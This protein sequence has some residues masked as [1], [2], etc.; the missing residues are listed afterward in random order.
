MTYR[1]GDADTPADDLVARLAGRTI[2]LR[3]LTPADYS[4]LYRIFTHPENI[5]RF[6]LTGTTPSPESFPQLLWAGVFAQFLVIPA[7]GGEGIG[8]VSAYNADYA[9]QFAYIS[10]VMH[11]TAWKFGS[12]IEAALLHINYIFHNFDFRKLYL[13]VLEPNYQRFASGAPTLF[14][15]E[16]RLRAHCFVGGRYVDLLTLA[17]Y[18]ERWSYPQL[19][20]L[21]RLAR[22][23]QR[24]DDTQ[25]S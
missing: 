15:Q 1:S 12:G 20:E 7:E 8:L 17:I 25:P 3:P 24:I 14:D 21:A 22:R 11:P 23:T 2:S 5:I 10:V 13:E 4:T 16:G 19:G 9:N 6:R 18:R